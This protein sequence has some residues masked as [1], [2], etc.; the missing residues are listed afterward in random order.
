MTIFKNP[1]ITVFLTLLTLLLGLTSCNAS[2]NSVKKNPVLA[3]NEIRGKG[4]IQLTVYVD[5]YSYENLINKKWDAKG[6]EYYRNVC[7]G[8]I[9]SGYTEMFTRSMENIWGHPANDSNQGYI[10][11]SVSAGKIKHRMWGIAPTAATLCYYAL[12][13]GPVGHMHYERYYDFDIYDATGIKIRSYHIKG[14]KNQIQSLYSPSAQA[15]IELSAFKSAIKEFQK[16]YCRD[17]HDIE[18]QLKT[19]IYNYTHQE[20]FRNPDCDEVLRGQFYTDALPSHEELND[21]LNQTPD[22]YATLGLMIK[23]NITEGKYTEALKCLDQYINLNPTCEIIY[24]YYQKAYL[25]HLLKR[26]KEAFE[27]SAA[28]LQIHPTFDENRRF[29]IQLLLQEGN[30]TDAKKLTDTALYLSPDDIGYLE[31]EKILSDAIERS[32]DNMD[33]MEREELM[34]RIAASRMVTAA[35][36]TAI[37]GLATL[38]NSKNSTAPQS[39]T[40]SGPINNARHKLSTNKTCSSCGGKGWIVGNSTP[41]FS[42]STETYCDDCHRIV[43]SSHSHD[44]CPACNGKGS[45]KY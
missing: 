23:A 19:G 10:V 42:S 39:Q 11:C 36:Q 27:A 40:Y 6:K 34:Q 41:S 5:P 13:G 31:M 43:S 20:F 37:V 17:I 33:S 44:S 2:L 29:L 12:M 28:A 24:P 38:S 25:F 16:Q 7:K 15:G 45:V 21:R 35:S 30:Y 9:L 8:P 1:V 22:D 26:E 14:T 18:R 4:Q 32:N 3:S